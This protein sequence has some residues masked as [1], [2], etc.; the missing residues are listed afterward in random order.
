MDR[1]FR[2]FTRRGGTDPSDLFP[3]GTAFAPVSGCFL[4]LAASTYE[5]LDFPDL[6]FSQEKVGPESN[7]ANLRAF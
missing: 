1:E 5:S 4:D 2:L 7:F 3:M 6:A